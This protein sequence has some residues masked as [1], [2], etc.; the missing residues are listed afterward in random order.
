MRGSPFLRTLMLVAGLLLAGW[1][2]LHLANAS[3]TSEPSTPV[4]GPVSGEAAPCG[5]GLKLSAEAEVVELKGRGGRVLFR[6]E[7]SGGPFTG[8]IAMDAA[9]PV[10]F[11]TVKWKDS[12]EANRFAKL[13]L[14]P[15]GKPTLTHFF[16]AP[17]TI[18][19]I[20]ELPDE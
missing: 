6:R 15:A 5:F 16:E 11:V 13:T 10:V 17:G 12:T 7:Q 4:I 19:D 1:G 18:G 8:M 2:I 3:G 14:E 20:W 9:E